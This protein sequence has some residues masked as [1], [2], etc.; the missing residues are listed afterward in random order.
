[1]Q[2]PANELLRADPLVQLVQRDNFIGWVFGIDYESAQVMTNDAWKAA[3]QGIPHNCFLV[4]SSFDPDQFARSSLLDREVILLRVTGSAKLPQ[5]NDLIRT[6][7]DHYQRQ[8]GAFEADGVRDYDDLTLNQL[9]FGGLECRV[10][11]T[12]YVDN[13]ELRLGSDL[14][15]FAAASR[16]RVY[17]PRGEALSTIVNYVDPL[18][19]A[20]AAAEAALLGIAQPPAPFRVGTVRYT[21]TIRLHRGPGEP[22]VEVRIQPADF[23][24]RRTAVLGMTRT[25]KSNMVKQ[26][27]AVVK[28]VA[29][30]AGTS[31]GQIIYDINGEYAN[32]NQQDQGALADVFPGAN[33]SLPNA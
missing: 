1:M 25:G 5:E 9:Q 17:R 26:T 32:A 3:A 19:R 33:C 18:R 7:I 21:S 29:D 10:L 23:L 6:K 2:Q 24:A 28:R 14:E 22:Q 13:G 31:I 15:S 11:G 20:A 8:L 30:H 12:F 16:L 27:V 4:A